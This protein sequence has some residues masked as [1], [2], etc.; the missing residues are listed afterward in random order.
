MN[1]GNE[2]PYNRYEKFAILNGRL[3][4]NKIN[5]P[6]NMSQYASSKPKLANFK[7]Q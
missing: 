4:H 2:D 3:N 1:E 6:P 5:S 7:I